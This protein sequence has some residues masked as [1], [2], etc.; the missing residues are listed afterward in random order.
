MK[1]KYGNALISK[2]GYYVITGG[3]NKNKFLHVL[4]W[5]DYWKMKKPEG[6]EIHHLNHNKLDNRIGN[7]YCIP[8]KIHRSYHKKGK[9]RP[10]TSERNKNRTGENHPCWKNHARI[11]K[12]GFHRNGKQQYTIR[13]NG[14][15]LKTSINRNKLIEW[16]T[17]EYSR[18][19][20]ILYNGDDEL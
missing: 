3:K 18:T 10:D 2:H 7:L 8:R 13:F 15:I 6:Y 16:F 20:L 9:K 19:I 4:I 11:I 17:K 14:K 5:E 12:S 1:T